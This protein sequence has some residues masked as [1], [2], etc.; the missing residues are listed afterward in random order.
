[1]TEIGLRH[2]STAWSGVRSVSLSGAGNPNRTRR[3]SK[4][5][6]SKFMLL[7]LAEYADNRQYVFVSPAFNSHL[8]GDR[9][10]S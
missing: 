10:Y 6:L 9:K 5:F 2:M 8:E 4:H 1:M 7:T 3:G